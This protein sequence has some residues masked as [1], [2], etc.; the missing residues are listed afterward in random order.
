MGDRYIREISIFIYKS[1]FEMLTDEMFAWRIDF[2]VA[3]GKEVFVTIHGYSK[4][5]PIWGI[6][7]RLVVV[8]ILKIL[9]CIHR[10]HAFSTCHITPPPATK[11]CDFFFKV[12]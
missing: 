12:C 2:T 3:Y 7:T 1:I 6:A 8:P 5:K 4:C 9:V 10:W 11:N